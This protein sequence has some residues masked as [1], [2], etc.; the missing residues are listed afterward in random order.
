MRKPFAARSS[1]RA[2]RAK[3]AGGQR[4]SS[5]LCE[6]WL[7]MHLTRARDRHRM[8]ETFF[9][10]LGLQ[11]GASPGP[12][13]APNTPSVNAV[14]QGERLRADGTWAFGITRNATPYSC[15]LA[16]HGS[17]A[18]TRKYR[19]NGGRQRI[20]LAFKDDRNPSKA[21]DYSRV[22]RYRV[23]NQRCTAERLFL[24]PASRL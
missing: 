20:S 2:F 21:P 16:S 19:T 3:A 7:T 15:L 13:D 24:A 11:N 22:A 4:H 18:V 1:M 10:R 6:S 12:E 17:V 9:K 23:L 14:F 5:N 8:A